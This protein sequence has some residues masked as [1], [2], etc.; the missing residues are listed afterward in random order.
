[1]LVKL[2]LTLLVALLSIAL[3][4]CQPKASPVEETLPESDA[5]AA[6]VVEPLDPFPQAVEKAMAASTETQSA[7]SVD[8][9]ASVASLWSESIDLMNEVPESSQN[10]Q[11]AQQKVEEY[12]GN[13]K[14]AQ[15]NVD[16]LRREQ[17]RPEIDAILQQVKLL[18]AEGQGLEALRTSTSQSV[19]AQCG[20]KMRELQAKVQELENRADQIPVKYS[21]LIGAPVATLRTCVTCSAE[22]AQRYCTQAEEDIKLVESML[23]QF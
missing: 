19:L 22:T 23:D 11:T 1:M 13:L 8:E 16:N 4:S 21:A 6:E 2:S 17:Y 15:Q 20:Q 7:Q 3:S 10:Y 5:E 12:G 18:L 9:W 14:Y